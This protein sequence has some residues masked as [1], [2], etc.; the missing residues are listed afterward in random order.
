MKRWGYASATLLAA[1]VIAS[2]CGGG[3]K[4]KDDASGPAESP[5]VDAGAA[6]VITINAKNF[7]FDQKEIKVKHG[8]EVTIKL[9]NGQG[10]HAIRIDGYDKEIKGNQA[11]TFKADQAGE[12]KFACSVMC[13]KGHAEMTGKLIVE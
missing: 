4:A 6:N 12:F 8:E 5:T 1:V 7:E 2:G 3:G 9:V 11:V 10:N 13:G